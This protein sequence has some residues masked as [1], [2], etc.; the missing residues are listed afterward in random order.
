METGL[1]WF[2]AAAGAV[3]FVLTF[4]ISRLSGE[5]RAAVQAD[6]C[7][8]ARLEAGL[9]AL[10]TLIFWWVAMRSGPPF[11]RGQTLA[12]GFLIG[13]ISS[14]LMC[15]AAYWLG[16]GSTAGPPLARHLAYYAPAFLALGSVSFT[17]A[18]FH[19]YPSHAV[20]GFAIGAVM[21]A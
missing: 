21:G 11:S 20:T 14:A 18:I 13:G 6:E 19:A 2:G 9:T 1:G 15:L 10:L 5:V 7:R 8:R 3:G 4:A 17:Y 16:V 12:Y